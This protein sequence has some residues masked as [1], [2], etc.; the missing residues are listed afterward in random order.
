MDESKI[1]PKCKNLFSDKDNYCMN[2]GKLLVPI[3][4]FTGDVVTSWYFDGDQYIL[5]LKEWFYEGVLFPIFVV[6]LIYQ[7]IILHTV[8]IP[9]KETLPLWA[10]TYLLSLIYTIIFG[11]ISFLVVIIFPS[12]YIHKKV[13]LIKR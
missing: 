1:C 6:C 9:T 12:V 11:A 3:K 13:Y 5:D 7:F 2:D 10:V 8:G 4:E